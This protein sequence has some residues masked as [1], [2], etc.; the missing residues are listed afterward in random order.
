MIP[1]SQLLTPLTAAQ[2]RATIVSALV[3]MGVPADQWLA[4]GVFSSILTIV[5]Q[6]LANFS[7]LICSAL[8][9][10]FLSEATGS[11][12]ILLAYYVYGV[13]AQPATFA[14]GSLTLLNSGGG[15]YGPYA[16]GAATFQDL[17]T[18]Q[19][20]TNA[21]VFTL[22]PSTS[23][24]I[25]IRATVAG[26][27]GS[28]VPGGVNC[29]VTIM[30]GVTCS[31]ANAVVGLDAQ[32]DADLRAMCLAA[33]ASTS[34]RG[35]RTAY[36]WAVRNAVNSGV[37]VNIN[38]V[39]VSESSSTGVVTVTAASPVGAPIAGDI[40]AAAAAIEAK[41]R[42]AGVTVNLVSA[43]QVNYTQ[44][45]TIWV[46]A[47]PGLTAAGVQ[48]AAENALD[49]W[50]ALYPIGGLAGS[51]IT[52]G[53]TGQVYASGVEGVIYQSN[54]AIFDIEGASNMLLTASQVPANQVSLVV[55]MVAA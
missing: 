9:G 19:T 54:N 47:L 25:P 23:L 3:A 7:A 2:I 33:M 13:T 12:L 27:K 14:N 40:T 4:G 41:V 34:V 45:I 15:T 36:N 21:A 35:P 39:S 50:F 53:Y 48:F 30:L 5:S 18:K 37:P 43:T 42:P 17:T 20:Y 29:L 24:T 55:H 38:R 1:I 51:G 52:F 26:S 6:L 22:G 32:S 44:T 10:Q 49:A 11:W 8:A 28:A 16:I 46:T 31:N